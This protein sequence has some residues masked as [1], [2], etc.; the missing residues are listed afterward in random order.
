MY[1]KDPESQME[2]IQFL[3]QLDTY[4]P[5]HFEGFCVGWPNPIPPKSLWS[6]IHNAAHKWIAVD[7]SADRVVGFIYAIS[8]GIV[9]A[10]VPLL[11]VRPEYQSLG[12]GSELVRRLLSELDDYYMVDIVCDENLQ[13]F[14]ARHHFEA[15]HAMIRR[16]REAISRLS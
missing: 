14:Y 7:T 11:E 13:G 9:S 1:R 3:N 15:Y 10:Y 16:N 5:E 4:S 6:A 2:T 12:I 8:D